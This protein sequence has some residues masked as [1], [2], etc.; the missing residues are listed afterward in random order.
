MFAGD[1]PRDILPLL[2]RDFRMTT[3][4]GP[5]PPTDPP[6]TTVREE[7]A[8]GKR[9]MSVAPRSIRGR[10]M[11]GVLV[12][13]P[14]AVTVFL[15]SFVYNQALMVGVRLINWFSKGALWA[16]DL[17]FGH[18]SGDVST[19]GSWQER[20]V[21]A[22][23][24]AAKNPPTIDPSTAAWYQNLLAVILTVLMLYMLGWLGTN[25]VGRRLLTFFESLVERI[26]LADTIYPAMKRMIQALSGSG[27]LGG[28]QRVVLVD[29][30][31]AGMKAIAFTT[32]RV[33]DRTTGQQLVTVY[34]PTTPNPT[35][36]YMLMVPDSAITNT[37]WT[38][39]EALSMIL[40][41]GATAR[42]SV[43][44]TPRTTA[45]WKTA[46]TKR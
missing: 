29:F 43:L 15:L 35:S 24:E 44:L 27:K 20:L 8:K 28:H 13:M 39:E 30:P 7:P 1:R 19:T 45:D 38:M 4:N 2:N 9:S 3:P 32:N 23:S 31:I 11:A 18:T 16:I 40:S 26:P 34:V 5:Q 14:L 21:A 41:G 22:F 36:G 10:I 12:I 46:P 25:V 17:A 37:D 33:T 6:T 42:S